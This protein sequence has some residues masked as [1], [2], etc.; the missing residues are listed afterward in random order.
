MLRV[1]RRSRQARPSRALVGVAVAVAAATLGVAAQGVGAAAQTRG[2]FSDDDG[3][4]HE[5]ALD[6][7]AARGVLT[8]ME[9]SQGLICP[10]EPLKRWEMAVWLVRVLDGTDPAPVDSSRFTDVDAGRWWAPFVDR[11]Y[12]LGV[13][14]G[15][16]TEPASALSTNVCARVV[17]GWVSCWLCGWDAPAA[18]SLGA[19]SGAFAALCG[20]E[21]GVS[22]VGVAPAQV[23]VQAAG[24]HG[25]VG[26]V[27]VVEHGNG[28]KCASMG[29]AQE[30]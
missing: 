6:A 14:A 12:A 18:S 7:L 4:V 9:C 25:V 11:L 24:Q 2:H 17:C 13:T 28:P 16:A 23:G 30:L 26:M 20:E 15:C 29:L 27:R 3:S 5:V 10:D 22:G 1:T 8:G 21:V 19:D